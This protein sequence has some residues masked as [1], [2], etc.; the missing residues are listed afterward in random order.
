MIKVGL[1][2]GIGCGKSTVTDAFKKKGIVIVDADQIAREVVEPN[3]PALKEIS[4]IFGSQVIQENGTLDRA[5]LKEQVFSNTEK[6]NQLEAILHP[7]I[8]AAIQQEMTDSEAFVDKSP[9]V[10]VDIPLLLEKNYNALFDHIVVV[11]C[12]P[13]Q[14]IERVLQ[15]DNMDLK[16]IKSIISKQIQRDD[17][18]KHADFVLDN[19]TTKASLLEQVD[20]LHHHFIDL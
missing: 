4:E 7:K 19:S 18:L 9:Y 12:L 6:L 10:I 17:R 5:A 13:E 15:R 3:S 11:D 1:T 20:L 2:G 16:I 8:K 14:Q